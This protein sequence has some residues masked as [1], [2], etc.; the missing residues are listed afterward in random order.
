MGLLA[1]RRLEQDQSS[2]GSAGSDINNRH[3]D[4]IRLGPLATPE[5]Y[6]P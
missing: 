6:L 4:G 5:W 3:N 2:F 1:Q